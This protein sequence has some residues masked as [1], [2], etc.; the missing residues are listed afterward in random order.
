MFVRGDETLC[1]GDE[2]IAA[3]T[4]GVQH[5]DTRKV[6]VGRIAA[7]VKDMFDQQRRGRE[8]STLSAFLYR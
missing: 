1:R 5:A 2:E 7:G 3:T 6:V 4:S 8:M